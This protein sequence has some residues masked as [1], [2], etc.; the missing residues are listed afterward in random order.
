M[1]KEVV[2]ELIQD[3]LNTINLKKELQ[4][5]LKDSNRD[6]IMKEY[7]ILEQKLGGHGAS[8]KAAELIFENA[9]S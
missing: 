7:G 8:R 2:K 5:I 3:D 6:S 9:Q 4:K 1:K